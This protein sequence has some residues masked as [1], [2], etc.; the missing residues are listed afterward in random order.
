MSE[1]KETKELNIDEMDN[2][3]G[4]VDTTVVD[5]IFNDPN[6]QL[7]KRASLKQYLNKYSTMLHQKKYTTAKQKAD[8]QELLAH[9]KDLLSRLP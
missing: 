5:H 3:T 7:N 2:V 9:V 6:P 4:G 8:L 1:N